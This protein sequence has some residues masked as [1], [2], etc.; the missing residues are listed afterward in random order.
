MNESYKELLVK[1]ENGAKEKAM[2]VGSVVVTVLCAVWAVLTFDIVMFIFAAILGILDYFIFLW[3]DV[4]Y[5]YLYLDREISV[6]KIMAKNKRKR[7][8]VLSVDKIEILAPYSSHELDSY[9][10]RSVKA[11]NYS[12]GQDLPDAKLYAMYYEGNQMYLL[13]LEE[14]FTK[15]VKSIAPR[16]VFMD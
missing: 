5:E 14:E 10:N 15:A 16:K 8:A 6:D 7:V 1:Q 2:R 13:N 3:T 11:T 9:R 12:A 4:E